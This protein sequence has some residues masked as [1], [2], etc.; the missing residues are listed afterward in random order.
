MRTPAILVTAFFVPIVCLMFGCATAPAKFTF[1]PVAE[2][3]GDFET[4]WSAIVEYFAIG[5]LPIQTIEKDSGL[6]VTSWMDASTISGSSE[7][8]RLCDCG[9]SGLT[10]PRWTRGKFSIFVKRVAEGRI[11]L[12]VTCTYEQYR[13]FADAASTVLCNSTGYL[14]DGLHE[15]VRAKLAETAAPEIPTF[16]PGQSQ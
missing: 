5:N 12:R 3:T 9:G 2:L 11:D 8:K 16:K 1:N 6:I 14:E 7:D 10:S 13:V 4:V 15:Y